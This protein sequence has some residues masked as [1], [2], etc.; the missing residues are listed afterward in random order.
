M[1]L[2]IPNI[3]I[4]RRTYLNQHRH[5]HFFIPAEFGHGIGR[6]TGFFPQLYRSHIFINQQLPKFFV[7][8]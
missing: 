1:R 4:Q 6:N 2:P 3:G 5:G 8:V 7:L